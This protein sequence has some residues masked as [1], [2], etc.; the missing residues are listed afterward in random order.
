VARI[1]R[2]LDGLPLALELAA[3]RLRALSADAIAERLEEG[4][5]VLGRGTLDASIEASHAL[6]TPAEQELYRRL[7]VFGSTFGLEDAEQ[8]AGG[9][10]L[11]RA[12]VLELLVALVEHSMVQ[13]EGEAP[14]R[15]RLL[16]AL[17]ADARG[18]LD[19]EAA[20]GAAH[21]H[22]VHLARLAAAAA[23]R[24]WSEG[25]EVAGDPLVRWRADLDAAFGYAM[26]DRDAELALALAAGQGALHHRLG[27]V[28]LGVE[29]LDAALDLD[30]GSAATRLAA[31]WWHVPL[32]LAE[33][34][35]ADATASLDRLR[36]L[37]AA[38]GRAGDAERLRALEGQVAL[39]VGDLDTARLALDGVP[40]TLAR[41]GE[42]FTA[43]VAVWVQGM[44]ALAAGDA[45]EAIARLREARDR[46]AACDDVCSLDGAAADQAQA[47]S[48]AG[49]GAE[50][51]AACE[52]ALRFAP[53]RPLG[54]RNTHL[55]HEAAL[56][57]AA[58]GE[59]GRAAELASAAVVA[60]RRDPVTIGPWHAP[61]AAGD[62]AL[63]GGDLAEAEARY[64]QARSLAADV[65]ARRGPSLPAALYLV[66]SE[67]R[68]A[69]V[70][71]AGGHRDRALA[72]A[73]AALGHAKSA[74]AAAGSVNAALGAVR[75]LG[76]APDP[77]AAR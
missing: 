4:H 42:W 75:R 52:Y 21:R 12:E 58:G 76:G 51:A 7:A 73:R 15:Y 3:A 54:E 26:R 25:A 24:V 16:E 47:A 38:H 59:H 69:E 29:C 45:A 31:L 50:A 5:A 36:E 32:L 1:C 6:L 34:R 41:R 61:A 39:S 71:E 70:A 48:L 14:R 49:A 30:G 37:V 33:L 63:L 23:D 2:R 67:L 66:A 35:V 27:T 77:V 8:V 53:E 22:A 20:R 74:P 55:L 60:A 65:H 46:Y 72:H 11:D 10:G 43:A 40:G 56:V 13:A 64:E 57:A 68:L 9:D 62:L 18:R 17:R 19:A 28:P 44:V